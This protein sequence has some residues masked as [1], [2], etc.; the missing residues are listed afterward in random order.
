M[1]H[2]GCDV[3]FVPKADIVNGPAW[4]SGEVHPPSEDLQSGLNER[5]FVTDRNS[6]GC[7]A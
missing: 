5:K 7:C 1:D 3:R 6:F 2:F 4:A